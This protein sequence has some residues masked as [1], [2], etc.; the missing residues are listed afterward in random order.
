MTTQ[1]KPR[2]PGLTDLWR[3]QGGPP[4]CTLTTPPNDASQVQSADEDA[5]G[6]FK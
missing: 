6:P 2:Q 3:S 4:V 1:D 5:G